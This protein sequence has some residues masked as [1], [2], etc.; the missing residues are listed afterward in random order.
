MPHLTPL[1]LA[2]LN[3]DLEIVGLFLDC[4]DI[5]VGVCTPKGSDA[6]TLALLEKKFEVLTLM[7]DRSD[8]NVNAF[9]PGRGTALGA[10]VI[11]GNIPLTKKLLANKSVGIRG[12]GPVCFSFSMEFFLCL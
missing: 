4:P 9:V 6:W 3:S 5:D 10:A 1:H 11:D 8:V 2:V 12:V 7:T